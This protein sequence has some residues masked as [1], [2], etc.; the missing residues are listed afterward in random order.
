MSKRSRS[1]LLNIKQFVDSAYNRV[2]NLLVVNVDKPYDGNNSALGYCYKNIN[3]A[4]GKAVYKICCSKTGIERTDFRVMMHEYG[5]IYLG[6]LD[7]IYE[8]LDVAA[9]NVIRDNRGELIRQINESCGI[10]FGESL[11]ER[12]IDDPEMNHSIHNIAM[13][14]EVN[15]SVLSKEDME[16]MEVDITSLF[17]KTEEE[18]LEYLIKNSISESEKEKYRELLDKMKK[19]TKIKFIIPER[20]NL[21]MDT[22]GNPIPFPNDKTY[23]EY[24]ILIF[25]HLDQFIKMLV[26]IDMGQ[27][28]DTSKITQEDIQR[29]LNQNGLSKQSAAYQQGYQQAM[30]DLRNGQVGKNSGQS[31]SGQGQNQNQGQGQGQI[32]PDYARGFADGL[33]QGLQQNQGQGQ[34][35]GQQGQDPSSQGQPGQGQ[36]SQ[37]QDQ[38]GDESQGQ[39]QGSQQQMQGSG[40]GQVNPGQGQAQGSSS[41]GQGGQGQAQGQGQGQGQ[42]SQSQGQP[43]QGSQQGSGSSQYDQGFQDGLNA[44]QQMQ[45]QGQNGGQGQG[46]GSGSGSGQGQSAQ[47]Q[48]MQDYQDGYQQALRDAASGLDRSQGQGGSGMSGLSDLMRRSGMLGGNHT[49]GQAKGQGDAQKEGRSD[50]SDQKSRAGSGDDDLKKDHGSNSR[51]EADKK[52]EAG[53][54]RAGGGVGCSKSGTSDGVREVDPMVDEVD[55]ALR[56]VMKHVKHRVVKMTDDIDMMKAWNKGIIPRNVVVPMSKSKLNFKNDIKIVFLIDISGSMNTELVDRCLKS[57]AVSLYKINRNLKYDVISWNTRLGEHLRDLDPKKPVP[58]ISYG[59]GTDMAAGMEYFKNN[60]NKNAV[61]VLISDFEDN[62]NEWHRIESTMKG[63]TM[64][65]FNYGSYTS[66]QEWTY[67]KQKNFSNYGYNDGY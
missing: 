65:G 18:L 21:G 27:N 54:I 26:S 55:M 32:D 6:H 35:Q 25:K 52:R 5:H 11:I 20:Y 47:N 24:F 22:M 13:D 31:Q 29:A 36:D 48:A 16:E 7:G 46:Q 50:Y 8:E 61:L 3:E 37:S 4:T 42:D 43:G 51:D 12:I 40:S 58:H 23:A 56:E 28:G 53:Q 59:G 66:N 41:Q 39:D 34:D 15:S 45:N 14:M 19:E 67:F 33:S 62:L 10:D 49:T 9:C 44:A 60:Y 1:D 2:G 57:I 17:P 64:Y 30:Q 38:G 63:Y